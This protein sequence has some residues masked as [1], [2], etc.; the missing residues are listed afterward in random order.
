MLCGVMNIQHIK[1]SIWFITGG[2]KGMGLS[3][4]K[5]LLQAGAKVA[6]TSR[7]KAAVIEKIGNDSNLLALAADLADEGSVQAAVKQTI[8]RFGGLDVVVNNA[9]YGQFGAVEE[10]SDAEARANFDVNVFGVLNVLRAALPQLRKQRSGHIFNI[11]SIAGI[12]GG[13]P[14]FGVYV[15][16]KFAVAGLSEGLQADLNGL[17]VNVT[18]VYPGYFRTDFLAAGS[19]AKPAREIADYQSAHDLVAMHVGDA[20]HGNQPGDPDKLADVLMR[21]ATQ[22]NPPLHLV[23]GS[24]AL[25][26]AEKKAE[27]LRQVLDT[28]RAMSV[29]TDFAPAAGA[30]K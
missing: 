26:L 11:A 28:N 7:S 21:V 3:L 15:A 1:N 4:A 23:L 30:A 2:S 17:G 12:T 24:D 25:G 20:I 10:V 5:R 29:S 8:A 18:C 22:S 9:G 27:S 19:P 16:T 14:G 13:F 6:V